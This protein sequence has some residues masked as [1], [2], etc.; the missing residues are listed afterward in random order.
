MSTNEHAPDEREPGVHVVETIDVAW[1]E[2]WNAVMA[3]DEM[4][5]VREGSPRSP[6]VGL[7][8][9]GEGVI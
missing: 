9:P 5:E 1:W 8:S 6:T 2:T 7:W 4:A 3:C